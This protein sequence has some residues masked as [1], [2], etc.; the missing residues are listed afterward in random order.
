MCK[1]V[2]SDANIWQQYAGARW[3][4]WS[5][6][7]PVSTTVPVQALRQRMQ[8]AKVHSIGPGIRTPWK[9]GPVR[10]E[11]PWAQIQSGHKRHT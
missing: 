7:S 10:P 4:A 5:A 6:S 1:I 9:K 2:C 11:S 3:K 8:L